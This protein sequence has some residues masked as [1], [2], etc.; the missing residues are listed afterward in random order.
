MEIESPFPSNLRYRPAQYVNSWTTRKG[1]I[2][3]NNNYNQLPRQG[4]NW[5]LRRSLSAGQHLS[6]PMARILGRTK[7][8]FSLRS[9]LTSRSK[10]RTQSEEKVKA[11]QPKL[12]PWAHQLE[13]LHRLRGQRSFALLMAMRTGKT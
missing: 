13:A 10:R 2:D 3:A 4:R 12:E 7:G 11:Y 9:R 8:S 5:T 1:G 6:F